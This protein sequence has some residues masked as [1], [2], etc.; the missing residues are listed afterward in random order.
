MNLMPSF[1]KRTA[2]VL[3][4]AALAGP[5]MAQERAYAPDDLG[6]LS[7]Y[8]QTRVISLEYSEQSGGRRI[9][10]DQLRF[11]L[12]Q[13]N[14]SN[15]GFSQIKADISKSLAGSSPP[16]PGAGNIRCES[17]D[18]RT[19][20]C[21]TPWS[22]HSQL[23]R[24][25]SRTP[26]VKG[27]TWESQLGQVQ[28][29]D[30]C[31]ADFAQATAT[32]PV[33]PNR[34]V[35]VVCGSQGVATAACNTP[36]QGRSRL[37][38]QLSSAACVEGRTW[39]W[40]PGKVWVSNGC[41]GEFVRVRDTVGRPYS[42]TCSSSGVRPTVCAWD[43]KRGQPYLL[44]QLSKARCIEGLTWGYKNSSGNLWVTGGCRASFAVR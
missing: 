43:R 32:V 24:E 39:G 22:G 8:D 21:P 11:Y 41:R 26:C 37:D 20:T 28:V 29:S 6:T 17:V 5:L 25:L 14:R 40:K 16:L 36:W 35:R 19:Q 23:V 12:D 1:V 44:K 7:Q 15:W 4:L 42:V 3:A 9:P 10:D 31:R 30:G 18:S 33:P 34:P 38:R 27:R 2:L 13:I